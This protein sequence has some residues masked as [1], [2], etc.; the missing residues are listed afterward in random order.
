VGGGEGPGPGAE[1]LSPRCRHGLAAGFLL[2]LAAGAVADVLSEQALIDRVQARHEQAGDH[3]LRC[4]TPLIVE[5]RQSIRDPALRAKLAQSLTRPQLDY[6]YRTPSGNFRV[7][8][9]LAGREAVDP[10]DADGDNI[11]DYV[12]AAAT[13]LDD[14]WRLEVEELG[15][16]APPADGG[17]DGEEYDVYLIEEGGRAYG[18][19][20][21]EGWETTTASYIELDNN[22]A[23]SIYWTQGLA[24]L[25]VTAAHE[26]FH[27]IQF[28][29]YQGADGI[30]WQEASATWMEEVAHP[31]ADDYVHYLAN[32]LDHPEQALDK[33][34]VPNDPHTYGAALF[35]HF[36]DQRHR[37]GLIRATWEE[38]GQAGSAGLDHFDRV[39]RRHTGVG[40]SP[41][42]SEFAVWNYFTGP[43]H[44]PGQFY[45]EGE[46]YPAVRVRSPDTP[47]KVAVRQRDF[48]DHLASAYLRLEPRQRPGGL[49]LQFA[50]ERGQWRVQVLL[51]GPDSLHIQTLGAEPAQVA[52]WDQYSEVVLVL[53]S[54][55][56]EG[57]GYGYELELEYDPDL[58]DLPVPLALRLG[59]GYPNPFHP[60]HHPR[61]TFPFSLDQA[62]AATTFSIFAADGSLVRRYD[63]GPRAARDHTQGWDG[64]NDAGQGVGS[65]VYYGLLQASQSLARQTFV[66]VRD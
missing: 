23:E 2:G 16:Q 48:L 55:E 52:G 41:S 37:R 25:Q 43:R 51:I 12:E 19:T 21:P 8:Y 33:N 29:Y 4:G 5:A 28:G 27:A 64:R 1:P 44:R 62:S 10:A 49:A 31:E 57:I 42:V 35:A 38:W 32:F 58:I 22:Y 47:A 56:Q 18:F 66:L 45:A 54:A 50:P 6:S 9:D 65:G 11:P 59:S 20:Y 30:W 14:A 17:V 3:L 24:G 53:S 61:I 40:L 13:A 36:L 7:H 15:Y 63:L 39:L 46:K 60:A 34:N 26:F